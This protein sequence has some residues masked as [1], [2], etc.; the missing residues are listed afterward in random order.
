MGLAWGWRRFLEAEGGGSFISFGTQGPASCPRGS[1][2]T[3]ESCCRAGWLA[4]HTPGVLAE[5]LLGGCS[6][7]P[8]VRMKETLPTPQGEDSVDPS[9]L[10]KP[11][12][13]SLSGK[14]TRDQ[15]SHLSSQEGVLGREL[16]T[17]SGPAH[18]DWRVTPCCGHG[19]QDPISLRWLGVPGMEG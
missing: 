8:G 9:S 17:R 15:T 13:H 6:W 18:S 19:D 4:L 11:F 5:P 7:L 2:E 3:Q 16:G 12:L 1:Q 14:I 10:S